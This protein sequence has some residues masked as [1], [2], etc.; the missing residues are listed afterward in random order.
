MKRCSARFLI[1][2]LC[3][4]LLA[5]AC[6]LPAHAQET[7]VTVYPGPEG[8]EES[9]YYSVEVNGESSFAYVTR[10]ETRYPGDPQTATFTSFS[11]E[12]GAA[13]VKIT[14]LGDRTI[15]DV[16]VRPL[17][18]GITA[19]V[20]GNVISFTLAE[21][22]YLS[23]EI[24]GDTTHKCFIFADEPEQNVP[25]PDDENVWYF[26]PGVYDIGETDIP[27]GKN[28]MYL[29]GGAYVKGKITSDFID[30]GEFQILGR[31]IFSGENNEHADGNH[32]IRVWYATRFV[33]D[34]PILLDTN[35][36]HLSIKRTQ[37]TV[38]NPNVF[39]N[40]KEVAWLPNSDGFHVEQYFDVRN[41]FIY[42]YDD[43]M[44]IS[45]ISLGGTVRDCVVWNNNYG[46]ALLL[47]WVGKEATGNVTVHNVDAI[48]FNEADASAANTAVIMANHGEMGHISNVYV[49]DLHVESFDNVVQRLFSIRINKSYWSDMTTPFGQISNIHISNVRVDDEMTS[50]VILG[51]DDEH[52]VSGVLLE[53]IT[54]NGVPV[55]GLSDLKILR[56]EFAKNLRYTNSYVRN[57][58]F[59]QGAA[60]WQFTENAGPV[61]LYM[62]TGNAEKA[63]NGHYVAQ[64]KVQ[65]SGEEKAWQQLTDLPEGKYRLTVRVKTSGTY[66]TAYVY[67]QTGGEQYTYEIVPGEAYAYIKFDGIQ[68][69][70]GACEI[71]FVL[72]ASEPAQIMVDQVVFELK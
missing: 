10:R 12:G 53:N 31:G 7:Q 30:R 56:N 25:S 20:E 15:N 62:E 40:L 41:L 58:S 69:K 11:F 28:I 37:A 70:D 72:N 51:K 64:L 49:D 26:G 39:H 8:I 33:I 17:D 63:Y 4:W 34:G 45:Q 32:L 35:S 43:A 29:A 59:E 48:H 13:H 47:G 54:V 19:T 14:V 3:G 57:G 66:D 24:N 61:N 52:A 21:P 42:N 68:V 23:V 46:S 38:D 60:N 22:A 9:P 18:E 71:G 36:F 16:V 5:L 27:E 2:T 55:K 6:F 44:D 1:S 50:N 65:Q 67:A